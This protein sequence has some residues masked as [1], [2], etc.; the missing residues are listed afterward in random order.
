MS[1]AYFGRLLNQPGGRSR[2]CPP[3]GNINLIIFFVGV[4]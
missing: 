1:A 4:A 3:L 2:G